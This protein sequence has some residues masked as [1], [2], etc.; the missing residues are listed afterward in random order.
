[1]MWR[2]VAYSGAVALAA[3][4]AYV[5]TDRVLARARHITRPRSPAPL[6]LPQAGG[7]ARREPSADADSRSAI[8]AV[9]TAVKYLKA[10]DHPLSHGDA[11]RFLRGIT[12]APLTVGADRGL[13]AVMKLEARLAGNKAGFVQ[14]WTLGW[15]LESASPQVAQVEIWTMGTVVSRVEVLAPYWSTTTCLL[16]WSHDRWKVAAASS[17]P[18][19]TPPSRGASAAAIES[20]VRS[21]S[22][23]HPFADEA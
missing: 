22:S 3:A 15:R 16:R 18:G 4:V 12:L 11:V 13:S 2:G 14:G 5:V 10:F 8:G 1:M 19:P 17:A 9:D 23:F 21:A 20:F 7:G 6:V